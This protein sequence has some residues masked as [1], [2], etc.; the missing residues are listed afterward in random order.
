MV[1]I[2]LTRLECKLTP[3]DDEMKH[4]ACYSMGV[5]RVRSDLAQRVFLHSESSQSGIRDRHTS[6]LKRI[7]AAEIKNLLG[8]AHRC[9]LKGILRKLE[10]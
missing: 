7:L 2:A 3:G 5:T 8:L 9:Q 4:T 1:R 10:N 6:T